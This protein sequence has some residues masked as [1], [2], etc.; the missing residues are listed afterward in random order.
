VDPEY[1][2]DVDRHAWDQIKGGVTRYEE[3]HGEDHPLR[4]WERGEV[5]A[6]TDG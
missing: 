3:I 6:V 1:I 2:A 5:T 4:A